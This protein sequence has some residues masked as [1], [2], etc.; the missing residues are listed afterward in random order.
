MLAIALG[1]T[2]SICW[3]I[4]DFL[5]GMLSRVASVF[6]VVAVSQAIGFLGA[7][8]ILAIAGS[9]PPATGDLL[10]AFVAG[11][12][13]VLAISAFFY[14]L[15]QGTMSIVA[16]ISATGVAVPVITDLVDGKSP[17]WIQ[18]VGMALAFLG[19]LFASRHREEN[20]SAAPA[21][22]RAVGFALIAALGFGIF[23]VAMDRAADVGLYWGLVVSRGV[24]VSLLVLAGLAL[25]MRPQVGSHLPALLAIGALDLCAHSFFALATT[26][27]LVSVVSVLAALYPV[28]TVILAV[29]F[30]KE[31]IGRAQAVGV[32]VAMVGVIAIA[33]G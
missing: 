19:V 27:G 21:P 20:E 16:P 17:S 31:R 23:Y 33:G 4:S 18:L 5:G 14:A 12:A 3:G 6:T 29:I 24:A 10:P 15:A 25:R 13:G 32:T 1:L 28:T 11:L 22:K 30:L 26:E 7:L 2:A 9:S 8:V